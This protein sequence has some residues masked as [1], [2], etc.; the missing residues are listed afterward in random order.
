[1][2]NA[3]VEELFDLLVREESVVKI[4]DTARPEESGKKSEIPPESVEEESG[5]SR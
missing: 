2:K 5:G 3:D 1:M 4:V